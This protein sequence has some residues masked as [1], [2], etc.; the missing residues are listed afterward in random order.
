[1]ARRVLPLLVVL[2]VPGRASG[3]DTATLKLWYDKPSGGVWERAL[4]VGNGRLGAMVYGNPAKERLQLNENTVWAGSPYRNDNPAAREALPRVRELV[5]DERHAEAQQLAG[6]TFFAARYGMM[7]QPVGSLVLSF[8]GH[9]TYTRYRRELDLERAVATT[10]YSAQGTMFRREV[11]ASA[12]DEIIAVRLTADRPG[13]ITF[14]AS[15]PSPQASTVR[16]RDGHQLVLT[17]KTSDH[18]GVPGKV[19]FQAIVDVHAES[20]TVSATDT[21][22]SVRRADAA[23]IYVSIASNFVRYDDLGGD[24]AARAERYL[25]AASQRSFDELFEA[26]T[27]DYR[28]YFDRVALNLG[29]T[30]AAAL[31]TD[32]RLAAFG[33]ANDPQ[34]VE[35][36]FQFGRYLLIASS[37][38]G[39][40]PANLQG[41]WNKAMAPPW[42]SKYTLNINAEMN[43]WPAELTALSEMHEPMIRMVEELS[44]TGR[45]TARVMY[46]AR[47]WATHHNTD[48]WRIT[49]PVDG[50]FWGLWPMGGAWLTHRLW[51]RYLYTGDEAYLAE[52]YP[53]LRGAAEFFV[54][55]LVKHPE[56]GWLVV[57]PSNSPENA[58]SVR[59]DV[60]IAAGTT[61]DN[62]L[63]FE[64]FTNTIRAAEVLRID[65]A[66]ADT[67]RA[68]RAQLPPMQVGHF[69]QLQEWL[70]DLDDPNDHHRH[71]SHLFG[72]YPAAQISPYRTPALFD[73][74][75][76]SLEYRG[77]VSTGWSM[78]WK[79]NL[80]ARLL[81]GD[82]ALELIEDQ[83]A[84]VGSPRNEGEGGTY[85]NLFDAHPPF[86]IDGNF[87]CTAGIAEM[88]LQSHDGAIHLLPALPGAWADGSV[89]GLRARGGFVIDSLAWA[90]GEVTRVSF[91]STLGGNARLRV[92]GELE[93]APGVTLR[94]VQSEN[95]NALYATDD[96]PRPIVSPEAP[97][98]R[99]G[100]APVYEYD[101][102]T[103]AGKTY[104]LFRR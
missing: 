20:G 55:F 74:A 13:Q 11:I 10:S 28:T 15:L 75:R 66:F 71:V 30:E 7:Y 88:L 46:G 78:G 92:H 9:D 18:E 95:P 70:E 84:P 65:E 58:P 31:P 3:Q 79:V 23:T 21:S 101:I 99:A 83:L 49:G 89:A 64:L 32:E 47:G 8:P 76:T 96:V 62:Q 104:T 34:L 98:A 69:G 45:E 51:E 94:P 85:P 86:Q 16:T 73:A 80:W 14:D 60:S 52:V 90:D 29:T 100:V 17:G 39:T 57:V 12:P 97:P 56:H 5:F 27:A 63:V 54:D 48:L 25:Q 40:Q 2:L 82:H 42:D 26:H 61:M 22:L 102:E 50:V 43:Y 36:Y 35:L 44:A 68:K 6:E 103:E 41:I 4:P 91:T 77:D 38:A 59:P 87:G 93:R 33:R 24:E 72:L 1:M 81:D 67:L 53:A 37:R 19:R